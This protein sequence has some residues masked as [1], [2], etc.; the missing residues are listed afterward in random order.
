M[1]IYA[2]AVAAGAALYGGYQQ[3]QAQKKAQGQTTRLSDREKAI[4]FDFLRR[5]QGQD[6]LFAG[7]EESALKRAN[8]TALGGYGAARKAT[9]LGG[10]QA[11]AGVT[12]QGKNELASVEQSVVGQ[13]LQGTSVGAQAFSGVQ[14]NTSTQL[15]Q[16]DV[17]LAQQFAN[18]GLA[19]SN[20]KAA[21]ELQ[22]AGLAGKNREQAE[23]YLFELANVLPRHSKEF[24]EDRDRRKANEKKRF[25]ISN[26]IRGAFTGGLSHVNDIKAASEQGGF[27]L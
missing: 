17:Q 23:S 2:A 25:G 4:T 20:T 26:T 8:K 5:N 1:A 18:L 22:L 16:I 19:E 14:N 27:Y 24:Y 12:Q 9:E 15:A 7:L 10:I 3:K 11:K 21:G 13:G 6:Q